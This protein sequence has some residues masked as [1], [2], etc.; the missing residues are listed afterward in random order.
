MCQTTHHYIVSFSIFS[1]LVVNSLDC[2]LRTRSSIIFKLWVEVELKQLERGKGLGQAVQWAGWAGSL[3]A[4]IC[5]CLG[6]T[7]NKRSLRACSLPCPPLWPFDIV[8]RLGWPSKQ[9]VQGDHSLFQILLM[10]RCALGAW[11]TPSFSHQPTGP[12]ATPPTVPGSVATI[13]QAP[14][15]QLLPLCPTDPAPWVSLPS[16]AFWELPRFW[17]KSLFILL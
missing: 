1:W 3:G 11:L 12:P 16:G 5:L 15:R 13:G 8:Y 7:G 9:K 10:P 14:A 17:V 6:V 2:I 4:E